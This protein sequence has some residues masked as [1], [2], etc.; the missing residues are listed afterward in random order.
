MVWDVFVERIDKPK[1][2][3]VPDEAVIR[4]GIEK[5][6]TCLAALAKLKVPGDWLL[7]EQL[8]L[9]DLHAAPMFWLF[10]KAPEGQALLAEYPSLSDWWERV[11]ALPSFKATA[12]AG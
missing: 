12:R 2:G 8:T 6:R 9:A 7:G 10:R 3:K 11:S 5:S 4:S 1:E